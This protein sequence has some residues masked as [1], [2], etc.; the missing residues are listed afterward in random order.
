VSAGQRDLHRDHS[1]DA[2]RRRLSEPPA[3]SYL[4]DFVYGAIDGAVTTFAIVAG[5]VGAQLDDSVVVILGLANLFADGFS[6][7]VSNFLGTRAERDQREQARRSEERHLELFPEGEREEVRQLFAAKGF[8]GDDLE[9]VVEVITADRERWIET[10][11]REELGY[12]TD[13]GDPL[14]AAAATFAA[15]IAIGAIPIAVYV[16]D[17]IV[18]G[19]IP[20]PFAWSTG[21]TAL[22][23]FTV[24]AVKARVVGQR[25][26][27]AGTET[28]LVGGAA[29][30]VAYFVGV[31]LEGVG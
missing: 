25:W 17:A 11:M 23:F 20:S 5:A 12:G 16:I 8:E 13:A 10:M 19:E 7:A 30:A 28:L 4:R 21:L 6:M 14:R 1:E 22:A 18:P 26:W 29:A 15:F 27:R 3:A 2:I 9:R 24:G 31:A